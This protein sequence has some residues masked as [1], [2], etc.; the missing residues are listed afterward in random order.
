MAEHVWLTI[1]AWQLYTLG[2][3]LAAAF[4]IVAA[5]AVPS[6]RTVGVRRVHALTAMLFVM[7]AALV[8]SRIVYVLTSPDYGDGLWQLPVGGLSYYGGLTVGLLAC[9]IASQRLGRSVWDV[10]D[11]I[12]PGIALGSTVALTIVLSTGL[13]HPT[14]GPMPLLGILLLTL[15]YMAT[16]VVWRLRWRRQF[17]G[18]ALLALLF[19]DSVMRWMITPYW[20]FGGHGGG[21]GRLSLAVLAGVIVSWFVRRGAAWRQSDPG[22]DAGTAAQR[23]GK[24][25]WWLGYAVL[26]GLFIWRTAAG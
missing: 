22:T 25:G 24:P 10:G 23:K 16:Y 1:G 4:I 5:A 21:N 18:Q 9:A 13:L 26:M 3:A 12:A 2:L 15:A 11:T 8:G 7:A 14:F 20:Q 6:W 17:S 19:F